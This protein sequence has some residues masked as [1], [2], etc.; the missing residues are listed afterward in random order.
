MNVDFDSDS[1]ASI[2]CEF[3]Q[4]SSGTSSKFETVNE[5]DDED[6]IVEWQDGSEPIKRNKE[7]NE[8][9]SLTFG[10]D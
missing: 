7:I 9:A 6:L 5:S 10:R 2:K 3:T 8:T 1:N 4:H